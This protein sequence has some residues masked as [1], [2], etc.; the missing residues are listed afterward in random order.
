M[1]LSGSCP[2]A[3]KRKSCENT[4]VSGRRRLQ[5]SSWGAVKRACGAFCSDTS[6]TLKAFDL[7][8]T[9]RDSARLRGRE[10]VAA[11]KLRPCRSGCCSWAKHDRRSSGCAVFRQRARTGNEARLG[12]GF[13]LD[14]KPKVFGSCIWSLFGTETKTIWIEFGPNLFTLLRWSCTGKTCVLLFTYLP[15]APLHT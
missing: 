15:V 8:A 14:H 13:Y 12:L 2:A 6:S 1:T 7:L 10:G 11:P 5:W 3:V 9:G 4:G